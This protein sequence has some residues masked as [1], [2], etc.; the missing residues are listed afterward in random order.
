MPRPVAVLFLVLALTGQPLRQ[1][2][3]ASDFARSLAH[4]FAAGST[5]EIP[6]GGVG[7][8]SGE[9]VMKAE[10]GHAAAS[11]RSHCLGDFW[12]T[13]PSL[14]ASFVLTSFSLGRS[15]SL[16]RQQGPPWLPTRAG[17]RQAWLQL[18]LV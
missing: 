2:E 6:D 14:S 9:A 17:Q 5:I 15:P 18:L 13:A 4:L 8:D 7:D 1:A 10:V 3:A 11:A 16:G 12:A